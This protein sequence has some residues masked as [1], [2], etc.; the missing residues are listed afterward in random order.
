MTPVRI[1]LYSFVGLVLLYL[2]VPV[3]IIVPMSFSSARFLS[4]PPRLLTA[5][6]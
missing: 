6:V 1:A 4:F 5:L 2:M 3:V